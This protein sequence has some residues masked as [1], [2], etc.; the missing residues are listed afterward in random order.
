ML[1]IIGLGLNID[2][3][4]KYGLERVKRCKKV[5]VE[6]YTVDFPYGLGELEAVIGKKLIA[7][8]REKVE[9]LSLVDEAKKMDVALL[10]YGSP[11]NP[12]SET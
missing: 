1:Y 3:I 2:G 8:D 11:A 9:S 4:S 12:S 6:S 5:Y 7:A 10:I